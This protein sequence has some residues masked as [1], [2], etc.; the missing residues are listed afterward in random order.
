MADGAITRSPSTAR[1]SA[2]GSGGFP[3]LTAPNPLVINH[4]LR[5]K[6]LGFWM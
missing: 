3:S 2:A 1:R 5:L 6:D 4:V